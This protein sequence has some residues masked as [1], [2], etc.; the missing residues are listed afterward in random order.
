[1]ETSPSMWVRTKSQDANVRNEVLKE[2]EFSGFNDTITGRLRESIE[3][4]KPFSLVRLGDGE[5]VILS[6]LYKPE[7]DIQRQYGWTNSLGYCGANVPSMGLCNRMVEGIKNAS[8]VGIFGNDPFNTEVF[9]AMNYYPQQICYAF[10]NLYLPMEKG[11]V[12]I[13]REFPPLMIGRNAS[14][15]ATLLKNELNIDIPACIGIENYTEIDSVIEQAMNIQDKWKW[16]FVCAGVPAVAIASELSYKHG[17]TALDMGHA[18]DN[19]VAGWV[20]YWLCK[21]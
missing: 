6:Q 11:F 12:D 17:K 19:I 20:D 8:V 10:H 16:A 2:I 21:E 9:Q 3:Q 4:S 1:M 13:L 15:Y 18:L 14:K 7:K 5:L